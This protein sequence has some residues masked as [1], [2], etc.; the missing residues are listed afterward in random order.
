M[1]I[2]GGAILVML[3]LVLG[4][5]AATAWNK[6]PAPKPYTVRAASHIVVRYL[7]AGF[8]T[9]RQSVARSRCAAFENGHAVK[10][11]TGTS[12]GCILDVRNSTGSPAACGFV[13]FDLAPKA[14]KPKILVARGIPESYCA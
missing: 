5:I 14:T 6:P 12:F 9:Q 10:T 4:D 13:R 11:D 7:D 8:Q 3:V 1:K 2:V